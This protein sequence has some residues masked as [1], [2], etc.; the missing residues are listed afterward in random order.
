MDMHNEGDRP[1]GNR[2]EHGGP[3]NN[4]KLQ[5][6]LGMSADQIKSALQSG[7]TVKDLITAKGLDFT[8]T[9]KQLRADHESEMKSK[10]AEDVKSGKITQ[11]Q[12]DA[13]E[14]KKK[15]YELQRITTFAGALGTTVEK[16]KADME[17]GKPLDETLASLGITKAQAMQKIRDARKSEMKSKLA[18]DVKSGKITQTQADAMLKKMTE[19]EARRDTVVAKALGMTVEEFTTAIAAGKTID[20]I[21]TEKGLSKDIVKAAIEANMPEKKKNKGFFG[22]VRSFL[23]GTF[24]KENR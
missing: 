22:K 4:V 18:E 20:T 16:I 6:I 15:E 2:G 24:Q 21:I 7:K 11:A 1:D 17:T 3:V 8:T 14:A 10:L 12:A 9:M 23:K 19:N 5:K 13:I